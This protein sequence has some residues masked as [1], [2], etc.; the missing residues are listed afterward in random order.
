ME[1]NRENTLR[2]G[3]EGYGIAPW[4][5]TPFKNPQSPHARTY[6]KLLKSESL[7]KDVLD[8]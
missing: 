6:N 7:L 1:E 8:N 4:L 5:M 3:D 2:L